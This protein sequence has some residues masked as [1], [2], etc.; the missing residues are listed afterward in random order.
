MSLQLRQGLCQAAVEIGGD[1]LLEDIL[2]YRARK[3]VHAGHAISL[4]GELGG[5]KSFA[6]ADVQNRLVL[7]G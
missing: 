1:V 7:A 3:D 2:A 4:V 6:A 5:E